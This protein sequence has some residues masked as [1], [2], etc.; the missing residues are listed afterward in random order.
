MNED[1]S[2][3]TA[4]STTSDSTV[5]LTSK[6]PTLHKQKLNVPMLV[7]ADEMSKV[8][9]VNYM[10]QFRKRPSMTDSSKEIQDSS[11]HGPFSKRPTPDHHDFKVSDPTSMP[12]MDVVESDRRGNLNSESDSVN[13]ETRV[14]AASDCDSG[15]KLTSDRYWVTLKDGIRR[16]ECKSVTNM[17]ATLKECDKIQ[18]TVVEGSNYEE[19]TGMEL[20]R[21]PMEGDTDGLD[22][23]VAQG[24]EVCVTLNDS[25]IQCQ[26]SETSIARTE[27]KACSSD[28]LRHQKNTDES[29]KSDKPATRDNCESLDSRRSPTSEPQKGDSSVTDSHQT[30][31]NCDLCGTVQSSQESLQKVC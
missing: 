1:A 5:M 16:P 31:H 22:V 9:T 19:D 8:L 15:S 29:A 30:K 28:E 27:L 2:Q 11:F 7:S 10:S 6:V 4:S 23:S 13:L 14:M 12:K 3:S 26:R 18:N 20:R 17:D 25:N 24:T 21:K